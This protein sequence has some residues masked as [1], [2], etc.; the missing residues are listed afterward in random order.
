M[1]GTKYKAHIEKCQARNARIYEAVMEKGKTRIA[2][3]NAY[4]MSAQRVGFIVKREHQRRNK[5]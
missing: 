3:G 4:G 2:V 1:R 5:A